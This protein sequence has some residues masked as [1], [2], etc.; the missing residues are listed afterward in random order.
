M[1]VR[2]ELVGQVDARAELNVKAL[3]LW[4]VDGDS[5]WA[6]F[7]LERPDMKDKLMRFL[8]TFCQ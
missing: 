3:S 4:S 6:A 2:V 7:A 5:L 8:Q 1:A